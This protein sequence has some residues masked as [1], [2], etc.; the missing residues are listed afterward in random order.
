MKIDKETAILIR[1]YEE[2]SKRGLYVDSVQLTETYNKVFET[3]A[4]PTGCG[5]CLKSRVKQLVDALNHLEE[6]SKKQDEIKAQE[7]SKSEN[8]KDV[9]EDKNKVLEQPQ[10]K[11]GRPRKNV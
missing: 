10:K 6:I 11:V 9:Q 7:A 3:N 4:K 5:Q 8:D 1:K 2:V